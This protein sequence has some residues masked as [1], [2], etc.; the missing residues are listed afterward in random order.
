MTRLLAER[1]MQL[2]RT[3]QVVEGLVPSLPGERREARR[4]VEEA[5]VIRHLRERLANGCERVRIA[6]LAVGGHRALVEWP[7]LTPVDRLVHLAGSSAESENGSLAG[8]FSLRLRRHVH[9][10]SCGCIDRLAVDLERRR[11]VED[12][13]ELLLARPD[14]VVVVD[15]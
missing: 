7:R 5:R 10:R 2:D 11:A 8:R 9:E 14:L 12:D 13:V 6:L 4:V 3:P 15:Q 1:R